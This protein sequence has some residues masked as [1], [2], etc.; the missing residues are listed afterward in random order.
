MV[1]MTCPTIPDKPTDPKSFFQNGEIDFKAHDVGWIVCGFMTLVATI[2]SIWLIWKHLTY[3][4]CPQQQRHIVRLLVMVPVYSIVSFLSYLFY[5]E[6]LYYQTIRDC[7]EA[8]L[9]TSFFY[10]ILA[11][12]GDTRA[13]QHAVFRNI[14]LEDRFWV[15]PL[16]SW[17][18]KPE[19]LHFLW[20]MKICVLQYAIIRPLCTFIA[21]GT[22]YFGYYCLHSWM[23]W[24][25][26]VWCA[27]FI[28]VSVTVAMYC[29]IQLY[30]PIRKLVDPYKPILKFLAVKTIVF[31]TF[32]QDTMLSFLVS[33][34]VIKETEYFTAEQ[35]QA[36]INA[37]LSC[38][39]MLIIGF[40]HIKA[41]SYL[42]YQP[43]DPSRTT[44]RGRALL[45]SLDYRDWFFE[46]KESSRY[47][48]ARSKGRE[49]TLAEGL[50][51]KR[52]Q[53]LLKA[54][55]K[56]RTANLETEIDMEKAALPTFW[57]NKD[58]ARGGGQSRT[59]TDSA[60]GSSKLAFS[61]SVDTYTSLPR[62]SGRSDIR[63]VSNLQ[64]NASGDSHAE[65]TAELQRL[66]AEL[67]LQVV[68]QS[69]VG[70]EDHDYGYDDS[71][72]ER[73]GLMHQH[74]DLRSTKNLESPSKDDYPESIQY[75]T[76]T[77]QLANVPS[78]TYDHETPTIAKREHEYSVVAVDEEVAHA[79]QPSTT[80]PGVGA[81]GI[82]SWLGWS[83]AVSGDGHPQQQSA[84][85]KST[86]GAGDY[87]SPGNAYGADAVPRSLDVDDAG[88]GWWRNYWDRM[89]Y[90]GSREPSALGHG[91]DD[92][93][94]PFDAAPPAVMRE[95][96]A[97]S[98]GTQT[99]PREQ[100]AAP[101]DP[102]RSQTALP[103]LKLQTD[104]P[105][106]AHSGGG[107]VDS[108]NSFSPHDK[109]PLTRFIQ[110]SRDSFSSLTRDEVRE[111]LLASSTSQPL[112]TSS[113]LVPRREGS[114]PILS[115]I[116]STA[117]HPIVFADALVAQPVAEPNDLSAVEAAPA[118]VL[119]PA[120][121]PKGKMFN[122]VLPSPLSPARFPYGKEGDVPQPIPAAS[123]A[124]TK[125][126][127]SAN[128]RNSAP[129]NDARPQHRGQPSQ[130]ADAGDGSLRW[131]N[132]SKPTK[133]PAEASSGS[134]TAKVPSGKNIITYAVRQCQS[135]VV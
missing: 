127:D 11:Y 132:Q 21:V 46:M 15:W 7:Y 133:H 32:W 131:A 68:D 101:S 117:K 70:A 74:K 112:P 114:Q 124:P 118:K 1:N 97:G 85:V 98:W 102:S 76:A 42:P 116:A 128:A 78:L 110:T 67:D 48:A 63:S 96:R 75:H 65:R 99:P 41:F 72:Y 37:L 79:R 19:G 119:P 80:V 84:T 28:S 50:R 135:D 109:S 58:H 61:H 27:F 93:K 51:A 104:A 90:L 89:S 130:S 120:V 43:E 6:A 107:S 36:G 115:N 8:V 64:M 38:F 57:K 10:L 17:K 35:I 122:L 73:A 106:I 25:T 69:I 52:H 22:E 123:S 26:H 5:K 34:N 18:Y 4:T 126:V 53:H 87:L 54:L 105:R 31:L 24:F 60:L 129:S 86:I 125:S 62:P 88:T 20:L 92:E 12:T 49:Y 71:R 30:M 108:T 134:T 82:A 40:V 81:G 56:E 39:E 66:V 59:N 121:G 103:V 23:P 9:V 113:V 100:P 29:L 95:V 3:Y 33:F 14:E 91:D 16:G 47:M 94:E 111:S 45:D 77:I 55:G 83:N 13:E 2:S 44:R